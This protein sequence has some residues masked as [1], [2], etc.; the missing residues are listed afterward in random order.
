MGLYEWLAYLDLLD[1]LGPADF[2]AL[3]RRIE[4]EDP[5]GARFPPH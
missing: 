1:K 3:V 2:I 4:S 5:A